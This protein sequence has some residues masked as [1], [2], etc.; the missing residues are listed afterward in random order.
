MSLVEL[1]ECEALFLIVTN[2][3]SNYL[4]SRVAYDIDAVSHWACRS[5]WMDIHLCNECLN[6]ENNRC[7]FGRTY[8]CFIFDIFC[9]QVLKPITIISLANINTRLRKLQP[10]AT[11]LVHLLDY[12][13]R[14]ALKMF[15]DEFSNG[16]NGKC[17][18]K[19]IMPIMKK[20]PVS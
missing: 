15:Y 1:K 6:G 20:T 11:H 16:K 7:K 19:M 14:K 3:N 17:S 4:I 9:V 10:N 2:R 5:G 12:F 18:L 13:I 8:T